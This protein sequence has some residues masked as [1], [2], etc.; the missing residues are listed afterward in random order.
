MCSTILIVGGIV[1]STMGVAKI[2]EKNEENEKEKKK[3]S[4]RSIGKQSIGNPIDIKQDLKRTIPI[5]K[6]TNI[7]K[8]INFSA[9]PNEPTKKTL[10]FLLWTDLPKLS[11]DFT[12]MYIA[13]LNEKEKTFY[14]VAKDDSKDYT[15]K[16]KLSYT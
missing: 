8:N 14:L 2:E 15:G 7:L 6:I 4:T 11:F 13:D 16:I 1:G 5:T 3:K 9:V 12:Q 10:E